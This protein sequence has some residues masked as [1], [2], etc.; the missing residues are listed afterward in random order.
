MAW[1]KGDANDDGKRRENV[2]ESGDFE[3]LYM[4]IDD[5]LDG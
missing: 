5:F 3:D 1:R 4:L 2:M